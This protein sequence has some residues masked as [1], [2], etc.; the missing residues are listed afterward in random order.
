M[1][2]PNRSY[3]LILETARRNPG[4]HGV[5]TWEPTA[6]Y[7]HAPTA[8]KAVFAARQEASGRRLLSSYVRCAR[9]VPMPSGAYQGGG[10]GAS[11]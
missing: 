9:L 1:T 5:L 4:Q 11:T 7:I 10:E 8:E 2:I 6:F 3:H